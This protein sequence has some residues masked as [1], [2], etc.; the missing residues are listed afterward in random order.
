MMAPAPITSSNAG[1]RDKSC[2]HRSPPGRLRLGTI[3]TQ[4]PRVMS[5][6][7][8]WRSMRRSTSGFAVVRSRSRG[9]PWGMRANG[10]QI[11]V[12]SIDFQVRKLSFSN[13]GPRYT[14]ALTARPS[15]AHQALLP[16]VSLWGGA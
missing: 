6:F 2:S 7:S 13:L 1:R 9:P 8:A 3:S 11:A 10:H 15:R 14:E 16:R 4:T 12:R 5:G